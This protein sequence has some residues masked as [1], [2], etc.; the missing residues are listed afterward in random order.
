MAAAAKA[1]K[2]ATAATENFILTG[3]FLV[4][5]TRAGAVSKEWDVD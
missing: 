5:E 1:A 4:E 2:A 3:F